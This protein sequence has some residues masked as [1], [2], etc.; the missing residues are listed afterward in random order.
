MVKK[1]TNWGY[2]PEGAKRR[3]FT[4]VSKDTGF[5]QTSVAIGMPPKFIWLRVGNCSSAII[6]DLLRIH[7]SLISEFISNETDSVLVLERKLG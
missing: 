1:L 3:G 6:I 7:H 2:A 5:Y 4:V